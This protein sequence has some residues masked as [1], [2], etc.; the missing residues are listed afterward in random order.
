MARSGNPEWGKQG[1][2]RSGPTEFDMEVARLRL[3]PAQFVR[4]W[5]LRRWCEQNRNRVYIPE[6]LLKEWQ[7]I[8]ED[9]F[10]GA[11]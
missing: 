1:P 2:V 11:A 8:V 3:T 9:T 5:Q 6:W 10:N 4:S 7:I